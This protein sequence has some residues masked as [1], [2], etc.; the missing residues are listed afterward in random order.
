[1]EVLFG[2]DVKSLS[3][4]GVSGLSLLIFWTILSAFLVVYLISGRRH[5]SEA[6]VVFILDQLDQ[7]GVRESPLESEES[8]RKLK[9][10]ESS[11]GGLSTELDIQNNY[12]SILDYASSNLTTP[13]DP[14]WEA[15]MWG[16]NDAQKDRIKER[17]ES[18]SR[19]DSKR[20]AKLINIAYEEY[21]SCLVRCRDKKFKGGL[22]PQF[23]TKIVGKLLGSTLSWAGT[24]G[25]LGLFAGLMFSFSEGLFMGWQVSMFPIVGTVT[26]GYF[27]SVFFAMLRY[28]N[29]SIKRQVFIYCAFAVFIAFVWLVASKLL[30][31]ILG[32]L[33]TIVVTTTA[34]FILCFFLCHLRNDESRSNV[35]S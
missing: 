29:E 7:N 25:T 2:N 17:F 12:R 4:L 1:M 20:S 11:K 35:G 26:A 9:K 19:E 5:C 32:S 22:G 14:G 6:I 15:W 31:E 33:L 27:R 24:G 23:R 28:R 18:V 16:E 34:S 8:K 13:V 3:H 30:I 10:I 21:T